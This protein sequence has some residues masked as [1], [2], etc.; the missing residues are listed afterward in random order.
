LLV[1]DGKP[2]DEPVV[3]QGP[4]VV[5]SRAEIQLTFEDY[6]VGRRVIFCLIGSEITHSCGG[7]LWMVPP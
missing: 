7:L 4:F 6:Q 2:I 5:D 1:I 3:G